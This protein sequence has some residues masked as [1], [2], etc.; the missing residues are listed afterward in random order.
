MSDPKVR[1]L[2]RRGGQQR[3][4]NDGEDNSRG[5]QADEEKKHSERSS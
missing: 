2:G 1:S 3:V 4:E 5:F